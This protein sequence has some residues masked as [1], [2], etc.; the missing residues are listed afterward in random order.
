MPRQWQCRA[1]GRD[2]QQRT[3]SALAPPGSSVRTTPL[4]AKRPTDCRCKSLVVWRLRWKCHSFQELFHTIF[5]MSRQGCCHIDNGVHEVTMLAPSRW[6][7]DSR[8]RWRVLGCPLR[9]SLRQQTDDSASWRPEISCPF[10]PSNSTSGTRTGRSH[11]LACH[12]SMG[13]CWTHREATTAG[14]NPKA[15]RRVRRAGQDSAPMAVTRMACPTWRQLADPALAFASHL[16]S[17]WPAP[18]G[19]TWGW[20]VAPEQDGL[21]RQP[22]TSGPAGQRNL[23]ACPPRS[24][25]GVFD[26]LLSRSGREGLGVDRG[27]IIFQPHTRSSPACSHQPSRW[28]STKEQPQGSGGQCLNSLLPQSVLCSPGQAGYGFWVGCRVGCSPG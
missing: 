20:Q 22:G 23:G 17:P 2:R 11:L 16:A 8:S 6:K 27:G 1:P 13:R 21:D 25:K 10:W 24:G 28:V 3:D 15:C 4:A 7:A 14:T 9:H 26:S 12:R 19:S 5:T 18:P